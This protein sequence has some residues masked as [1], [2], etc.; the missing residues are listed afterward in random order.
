MPKIVKH[1]KIWCVAESFTGHDKPELVTNHWPVGR[2]EPWIDLEKHNGCDVSR[3]NSCNYGYTLRLAAYDYVRLYLKDLG[4]TESIHTTIDPLPC[5]KVRKG[6][7]TRYRW[8]KWE[9]YLK[10]QG[11]VSV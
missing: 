6:I 3:Q 5:P 8:G 7:E 10:T 4:K 2:I 1:N 11:W 9:K